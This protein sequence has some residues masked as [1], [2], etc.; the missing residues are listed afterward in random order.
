MK[1]ENNY[2]GLNIKINSNNIFN[3]FNL[4]TDKA[5]KIKIHNKE[6]EIYDQNL[7][8]ILISLLMANGGINPN[9]KKNANINLNLNNKKN[10][11]R[12]FCTLKKNL[13]SFPKELDKNTLELFIILLSTHIEENPSLCIHIRKLINICLHFQ[14]YDVIQKEINEYLIPK[15]SKNNCIEIV[16]NFIDLIFEEKIQ[17]YFINLI[18]KGISTIAFYLPE[19]IINNKESLFMLSN[20]TLE[21]IIEIYFENIKK[22]GENNNINKNINNKEEEEQDIKNVLELLMYARNIHNDIFSLLENERKNA[23]KNFEMYVNE[24]K[25]YKPKFIWKIKYCDIKNEIYQEYKICLDNIN[26]LLISYYEPTKD[27]F[28]LAL[29][30]IGINSNNLDNN[31]NKNIQNN[32][33]NINLYNITSSSKKVNKIKNDEKNNE[34][35][36]ISYN[37]NVETFTKNNLSENGKDNNNLF[38]NDIVSILYSCELPEIGYKSKINFN[39]VQQNC[40]SKFL[41]FKL[42]NFSKLISFSN[43]NENKTIDFSIKFYFSRNY[44]FSLIISH[45]CKNLEIY[46]KYFSV[47]KIPKL[48]LCII[49]KNDNIANSSKNE[50]FKLV[51]IKNWLKNKNNYDEKNIIYLFK[52]IKWPNLSTNDLVEFFINNAQLLTTIKELKN[53]IFYEI[54]R[55]FQNEYFSFFQNDKILLTN[56][57][58]NTES[59]TESLKFNNIPKLENLESNNSFTF[60]FLTKILSY[61]S[62]KNYQEINN[63]IPYSLSYKEINYTTPLQEGRNMYKLVN[64]RNNN[65]NYNDIPKPKIS[66]SIRLNESPYYNNININQKE[67]TK[68]NKYNN[69]NK[70]NTYTNNNT[71]KL[72]IENKNSSLFYINN[73]TNNKKKSTN[74]SV[75]SNYQNISAKNCEINEKNA[76]LQNI[77]KK[78]KS[79]NSINLNNKIYSSEFNI[80]SNLNGGKSSSLIVNKSSSNRII[81]KKNHSKSVDKN[82][83]ERSIH[84]NNNIPDKNKVYLL[85]NFFSNKEN[86]QNKNSNNDKNINGLQNN[87]YNT[88]DDKSKNHNKMPLYGNSH[89][90]AKLIKSFNSPFSSKKRYKKNSSEN[91][92]INTKLKRY[93]Y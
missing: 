28:Q 49:L 89:S 31:K 58:N 9:N 16:I 18:K 37:N 70:R 12:E 4:N 39:C 30:V 1:K 60:D 72:S 80:V 10:D 44:I 7:I 67:K 75:I 84:K 51:L 92:I 59:N 40:D 73:L 2:Y 21:E 64:Q 91:K 82:N 47:S 50:C 83:Y 33:K 34:I 26:L 71:N 38:L 86:G 3:N 8:Q 63:E 6:Y 13:F 85:N 20:E 54:Q 11:Y 90:K 81:N 24:D 52:L 68:E 35:E 19:F 22:F 36:L 5:L 45:I 48:A 53:D 46:H 88:K 29:Q 15:I 78:I 41:V 77:N 74:S 62:T 43:N 76:L 55:R 27:I 79:K 66:K 32:D 93:N 56:L 17:K 14:L 69:L 61:F 87:N 42:D 25:D 23:L 57:Y 65:S